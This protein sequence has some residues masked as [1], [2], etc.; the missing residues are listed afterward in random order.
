MDQKRI[1]ELNKIA[2]L[3]RQLIVE[4]IISA[5][6]GHPGGAFSSVDIMTALYFEIMNIDP[7]N[8]RSTD[9]DR[10]ILSKGHSSV[11]LYSV[12]HLKGFFG[13]ETL[14]SFRQDN[15]SL[16][17]HP[18]MHKVP[19]IEMS[20]GSLG[21]GLSV[22][23]GMALAAKLN[24]NKHRVFVLLGDGET[25][26]GSVWEAAM[27]AAHFKLDNLVAIVDRNMIQIDGRTEEIMALEPYQNKWES[28]GWQVKQIDGH[29]MEEI[30]TTLRGIPFMTQKPSLIIANTIKGKGISFMENTHE[31]HGGAPKGEYAQIARNETALMLEGEV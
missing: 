8:P 17:G 4:A 23:I 27:S 1:K 9:R 16:S 14:L 15:S 29:N 3:A 13:Q 25:Q 19:G 28:F 24:K 22:G 2:S 6:C 20:T 11:G 10:F 5:G 21:H 26:E 7:Q 31:W 12:M 18:D 30:I